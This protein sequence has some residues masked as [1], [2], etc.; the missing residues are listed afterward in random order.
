MELPSTELLNDKRIAAFKQKITD[1]IEAEGL[2]L[3]QELLENYQQ[4]HNIPAIEVAAA[5]AKL[6]QGD[7]PLLLK[8]PPKQTHKEHEPRQARPSRERG[9]RGERSEGKRRDRSKP[10][11]GMET[12]RIEVGHK[13]GVKPGNIV[14]AIANEAG[15][16]SQNIGQI[17]IHDD[18]STV[19]LPE[20]MPREVFADL[21]KVW[22]SGQQLKIAKLGE[23]R[24][25]TKGKPQGDAKPVKKKGFK[26][27]PGKAK[28]GKPK[29]GKP[30]TG[31]PSSG[32]DKPRKKKRD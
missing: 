11:E 22:V 9:E 12:F 20:G 30:K 24:A 23:K 10:E 27:K 2:G 16:D 31:K 8:E 25:Y 5:L 13:H 21:Q 15:L 19:D 26:A 7:E 32:N 6:A 14:G 3:Y 18:Y 28:P 17:K 4:E 1:T 29:T